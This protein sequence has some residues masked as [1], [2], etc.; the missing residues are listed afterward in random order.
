MDF[1]QDEKIA[2]ILFERRDMDYLQSI[3]KEIEPYIDGKVCASFSSYRYL[4]LNALGVGFLFR[5]EE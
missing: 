3:K 1:L 4:E 5:Y 2:K